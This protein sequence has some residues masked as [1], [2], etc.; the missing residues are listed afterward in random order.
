MI[1]SFR[2]LLS[3]A[4]A[5][6]VC[7]VA[8]VSPVAAQQ[9][10]TNVARAE[11]ETGQGG[12]ATVESNRVET[13]VT[14]PPAQGVIAA[15]RFTSGPNSTPI[16]LPPTRC[17]GASGVQ[18]LTPSGAFSGYSSSPAPL[19]R[20]T[21]I[22]AGEPLVITLGSPSENRDPAV[23]ET[24][25]V[26]I[27]TPGGDQ[28]IIDL[29]E[30]SAN[31]G[32]FSGMIQTAAVPPPLVRNN[33]LLSVRPG[34]S[35]DIAVENANTGTLIG[36]VEVDILVD[37]FGTTFDSGDATLVNGTRV[38]IV[39][40]A[41]G[42]PA[43]V[44]GD[45]GISAYPSTIV[46]GTTVTDAAGT[47]YSFGP[48]YYRFPFMRPGTYRL[49]IEP[50]APYSAPSNA[51][52]EYL[53]TLLRPDGEPFRII[54]GSYGL[55]FTLSDPN[56]VEID[57]PLDRPGGPLGLVKTASQPIALAGDRIRYDL[58]LTNTDV[59]R[60]SGAITV[61]D[62]LPKGMRLVTGTVRL[63]GTS[64][65]AT[66]SS[67][68]KT[69]T[70]PV[71]PLAG[72]ASRRITYVLEV[73]PDARAGD[74]VNRAQARDSRGVESPVADAVVRVKRD[75]IADR[76]TI[77]GRVTETDGDR[78][79]V[80]PD[81]AKGVPG[82]RILL[83]DGSYTVTDKDG[84]YHFEGVRTGLHV[85]QIDGHTLPRNLVAVD[86]EKNAR[87]GGSAISRFVEGRGGS[88]HR[89]DFRVAPGP[90]RAP[91]ASAAK[92]RPAIPTDQ[93]AAGT[94]RDWLAGEAPGIAWL[95]P[96]TDH[97]PR[98][99]AVRVAIKHRPTDKIALTINGKP[100][101]PL[102]FDRTVVN[103]DSTVA[104]SIWRGVLL[105]DG[106]NRFIATVTDASGAVVQTLQ[107]DIRQSAPPM[108]VTLLRD[109]SVLVADGVTKP[110]IA[111]RLTDR[112]G[113]PVKHGTTGDF[114][115]PEPYY[116][117][118]EADAQQANQLS[119]LERARPVWR[120]QGD[121]GVAYIELE[122]TTASGSL[123][124]TLPFR[125]DEVVREQR[126]E[127]W[128]DPGNQPWTVVGFAA[129][130]IG[131][132]TLDDRMEN[133]GED[134]QDVYADGRTAFYAKGRV[135]GKW[136]LTLAYDSDK[137]KDDT[138]FGG[139]IDPN[140]YYTVYADGS[141][142]RHD[143]ATVRKLYVKLERPQF[144][145][146]FGDFATGIDRPELTRYVRSMNG[147]KAEYNNGRISAVL[148][149]ADTPYQYGKAE[150]QGAGITGPYPIGA[151]DIIANSETVT[152]E[153][154]DRFSADRIVR[155]TVLN[156]YVDYDIDYLQGLIIFKE[157]IL[158]R[159]SDLNP[160]F[161]VVDYETDGI[162]DR[163]TNAGGRATWKS[164]DGRVDIGATAIHD[165]DQSVATNVFG[166]DVRFRPT[167]ST[168]V[169]A[170]VA[171]SN[172]SNRNGSTGA[173]EGTALA[174]LVEAEHHGKK[175]DVL[176]YI[177]QQD[178]NFGVN[179]LSRGLGGTR[180]YGVD[181]RY[182]IT[183]RIS[184]LVSGVK[185]DYLKTDARRI[186]AKAELEYR[187][188]RTTFRAGL[189]HAND[190]TSDGR[191]LKSTLVSIGGTQRF[192]NNK[193]E[194]DAQGEFALGGQDE[195]VDYPSR[196]RFGARYKINKDISIAATYEIAKGETIDARTAR[197]GFD[198]RPWTGA[199]IT[200]GLNRQDIAEYGK[201]SFASFGLAQ[202]LPVTPNLTVDLTLD[203]N[204]TIGGISASDVIDP[205]QP[206]ASG[207]FVGEGNLIAEDFTAV[208]A[209]ATY[210]ANKWSATGR[211][212][213]R[214]GELAN[215]Y[216]FT[217]AALREIGDGQA[218]GGQMQW[219]RANGANGTDTET[220]NASLSFAWR[221]A[222]SEVAILNKLEYRSDSVTNAVEGQAGPIGGLPLTV[223]GDAK[224]R[225]LVNSFSLNWMPGST[226]DDG[227]GGK[228]YLDRTEVSFFWGTRYAFDRFD[229]Q[230][231]KGWS[232]VF[233]VDARFDITDKVDIGVSGS[234]R[235]S[236]GWKSY[237]FA[238]GPAIGFSPV[239]NSYISVGYNV[240]GFRDRDFEDARYTRSGPYL[241]VRMKFDQESLGSLFGANR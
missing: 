82:V 26:T 118:V 71:P 128:L 8:A 100:V 211:G 155:S 50:P 198:L 173:P 88:L 37:P 54:P 3:R 205:N 11:W 232:N 235:S 145:A 79:S 178:A 168:E 93:E 119:G 52:P 35:L 123:S 170:E 224:S 207:G 45:D 216:G 134:G 78:C 114:S 202:S 162:G 124:V 20:A 98:S 135:K 171:I 55:P 225:R 240:V 184:I 67:D 27:N 125:D 191:T 174:W 218:L 133:L 158:S 226:R 32:L 236:S 136:L 96:G 44:F 147:V 157:P 112:A 209:G 239:D 86:C 94:N 214:N 33:C 15:W 69:L 43:Q 183:D 176:A 40:S 95:F 160:Q 144:Y 42:Q 84:R 61:T 117:W 115:V 156:R 197:V 179:Q 36:D 187:T 188:D 64:V 199:R 193:L 19:Q 92:P 140:Q 213:Y 233:G 49:V 127:L 56:P 234:V 65:A 194:L 131:F 129:G 138:R 204:K 51:T 60:T 142:R 148:F 31:S 17:Q 110:V 172:A 46:T 107:H 164:A 146:L 200:T 58:R 111:I 149:A 177:R 230:D 231:I 163:V 72:G 87:S 186:A 102:S 143:A 152:I 141:E 167:A 238:G 180:K 25:R 18:T 196:Y 81:T 241:T 75:Q 90:E 6:L 12:T 22:R 181:V 192:F 39:D 105:Q 120:V 24:V 23:V 5:G 130:T 151:R 132:N 215:R 122:P 182:A 154:R 116:P 70:I 161:I 53:A 59:T 4:I 221:P 126:F 2:P 121:D 62:V 222:T 80:N 219:F 139:V 159:D 68:G 63:D 73:R 175:L 150:I 28:E 137:E 91:L 34:D 223:S 208:T 106:N 21:S 29:T 195:S 66:A 9:T 99:P 1:K 228:T 89:V 57:V 76:M 13:T 77:I 210:R 220:I 30:T 74:A 48:G 7:S 104:V 185:E 14:Q 83:E 169:R 103:G 189:I 16:P 212:E 190:R 97:N 101:E 229:D 10:I 108:N 165:E 206:V 109:Q 166:A 227:F 237:S 113:R 85:V 38:T 217:F 41:T 203:A 47:N 201:R 153:V